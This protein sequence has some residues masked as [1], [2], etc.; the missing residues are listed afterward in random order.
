M[1]YSTFF[2]YNISCP[3]SDRQHAI[4][5]NIADYWAMNQLLKATKGTRVPRAVERLELPS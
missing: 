3:I 2:K 5:A 1:N 4:H